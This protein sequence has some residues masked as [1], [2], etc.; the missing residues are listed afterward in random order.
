MVAGICSHIA[1]GADVALQRPSFNI[2]TMWVGV[3]VRTLETHGELPAFARLE[4]WLRSVTAKRYFVRNV[5]LWG[6]HPLYVKLKALAALLA[7]RQ[8]GDNT[9]NLDIL[10][11]PSGG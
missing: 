11:L 3:A 10:S 8:A 1:G 5:R 9:Y 2:K 4:Y 6:E 7:L